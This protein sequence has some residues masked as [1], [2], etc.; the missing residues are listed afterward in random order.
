MTILLLPC[1]TAPDLWFSPDPTERAY[2]ARQ[3]HTCP[4]LLP[5]MKQALAVG[6]RHGVWGGVDF[7]TRPRRAPTVAG[8]THVPAAASPATSSP[9]GATAGTQALPIAS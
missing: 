1:R 8:R 7:E 4:L 2:A 9:N 6:E 5:C 3:C